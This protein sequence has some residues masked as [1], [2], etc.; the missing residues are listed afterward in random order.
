MSKGLLGRP[1]SHCNEENIVK[2]KNL[3]ENLINLNATEWVTFFHD[4][5]KYHPAFHRAIFATPR[6]LPE[7]TPNDGEID[8]KPSA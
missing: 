6:A 5:G 7:Q 1:I 3:E 2:G 4:I 8:D